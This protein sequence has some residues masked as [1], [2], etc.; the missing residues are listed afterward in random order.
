MLY[1]SNQ[2]QSAAQTLH[3]HTKTLVKRREATVPGTVIKEALCRC[4]QNGRINRSEAG[5]I[6]AMK[7][8]PI[9]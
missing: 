7:R 5:A 9:G 2:F 3:H 6:A 4:Y 1:K 8:L